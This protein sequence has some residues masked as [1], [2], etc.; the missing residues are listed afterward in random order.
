MRGATLLDTFE[1]R[2]LLEPAIVRRLAKKHRPPGWDDIECKAPAVQ[3]HEY[4]GAEDEFAHV[5]LGVA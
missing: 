1:L 5:K 2:S 3:D 4:P